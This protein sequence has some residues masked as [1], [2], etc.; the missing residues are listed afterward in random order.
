MS[1]RHLPVPFRGSTLITYRL[2][3]WCCHDG[4][5]G[6]AQLHLSLQCQRGST[7]HLGADIGAPLPAGSGHGIAAAQ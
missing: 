3:P 1:L 7:V 6:C 2:Y 5:T 4:V